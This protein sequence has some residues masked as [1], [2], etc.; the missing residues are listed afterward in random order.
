[1]NIFLF[2]PASWIQ[3]SLKMNKWMNVTT[4][5]VENCFCAAVH[6]LKNKLVSHYKRQP[7]TKNSVFHKK[8]T[9]QSKPSG[10]AE[11]RPLC[12]PWL[13]CLSR[14]VAVLEKGVR[15][16]SVIR[17]HYWRAVMWLPF[18][19]AYEAACHFTTVVI[20]S[21]ESGSVV[22]GGQGTLESVEHLAY[23]YAKA[24]QLHKQHTRTHTHF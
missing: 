8:F 23:S 13:L 11:R 21:S 15:S 12:I 10:E 4:S 16:L 7:A 24:E 14:S 6:I 17:L 20:W 9:K 22:T 18:I 2:H 3:S 1:M 19:A 5:A